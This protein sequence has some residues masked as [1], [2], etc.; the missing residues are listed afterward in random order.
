MRR[1]AAVASVACAVAC[2]FAE[3]VAQLSGRVQADD[4]GVDEG[5]GVAGERP[6]LG[7]FQRAPLRLRQTA[8]TTE[9]VKISA[10]AALR[11]VPPR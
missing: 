10:P 4:D 5:D 1:V 7:R 9:R 11:R 6:P 2:A 3:A 8:A